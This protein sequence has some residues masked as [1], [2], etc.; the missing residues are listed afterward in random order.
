MNFKWIGFKLSRLLSLAFSLVF[1][2][3]FFL[4]RQLDSWPN[5][6]GESQCLKHL[7]GS[8]LS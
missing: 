5:V 1:S 6:S 7:V 2:L 8:L 4:A 3:A